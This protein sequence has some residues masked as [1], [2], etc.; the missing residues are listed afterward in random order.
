[1]DKSSQK[2]KC[3][4]TNFSFER[5]DFLYIFWTCIDRKPRKRNVLSTSPFYLPNRRNWKWK[6][7]LNRT[8][9]A[10]CWRFWQWCQLQ[11]PI[12]LVGFEKIKLHEIV[13]FD[14]YNSLNYCFQNVGDIWAYV[15]PARRRYHLK[16]FDTHNKNFHI[17]YKQ[18]GPTSFDHSKDHVVI[19][20]KHQEMM[21][22]PIDRWFLQKG[23]FFFFHPEGLGPMREPWRE[24][25]AS[26][27]MKSACSHRKENLLTQEGI[28]GSIPI[29]VGDKQG[30]WSTRQPLFLKFSKVFPFLLIR[31]IW[32]LVFIELSTGLICLEFEWE[33]F[34]M[35][36]FSCI[37][38][39]ES[40]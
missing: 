38:K 3:L 15:N 28:H 27:R 24:K 19:T 4:F 31:C 14:L 20:C 35:D 11:F 13:A 23:F 39:E 40:W 30:N 21:S 5:I 34:K 2:S 32:K 6:V 37:V 8:S 10:I 36:Y 29:H 18:T 25:Y 7:C 1:M 26:S 16:N 22:L 17:F 33:H 12:W 9:N